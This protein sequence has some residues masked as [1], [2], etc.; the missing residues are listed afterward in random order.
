[1]NNIKYNLLECIVKIGMWLF[2]EIEYVV[3]GVEYLLIWEFI[4]CKFE[5][6]C[7]LEYKKR[8]F[9]IRDNFK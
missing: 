3:V 2:F 8:L 9:M 5:F 1:M 6:L 4:L 7:F